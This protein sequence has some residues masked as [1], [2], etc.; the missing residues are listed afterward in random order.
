VRRALQ[1][2]AGRLDDPLGVLAALGGLEIACLAGALLGGAAR[3]M[4]VVADGFISGAAALAGVRICPAAGAYVFASHR[5]TEP[6]H[7]VVLDA[8][9][10]PPIL[11]LDLRLGEGTGAALAMSIIDAACRLLSGMATFAEAGVSE[12]AE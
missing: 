3:G 2:N 9:G 11:D 1:V 8:L 4:C 5:S 12:E 6:G 10:T 7:G